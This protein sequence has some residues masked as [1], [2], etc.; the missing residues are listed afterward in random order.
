MPDGALL[1]AYDSK[2]Y[3]WR[4]GRTTWTV[5]ADL[6]PLGLYGVTRIAVN[7]DGDRVA[8]VAQPRQP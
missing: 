8:I 4:R 5:A 6:A 3:L 7:P 2:L 1:M